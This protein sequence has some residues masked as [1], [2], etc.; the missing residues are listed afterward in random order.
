VGGDAVGLQGFPRYTGDI[1]FF[2]AL[3]ERRGAL[4][5]GGVGKD[6]TAPEGSAPL[7]SFPPRIPERHGAVENGLF[8]GDVVFRIGDEVA[9]ALELAGVAWK[10]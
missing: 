9:G 4:P 10:F 7:F 3:D 1:N 5:S 6:E 2:V 8:P